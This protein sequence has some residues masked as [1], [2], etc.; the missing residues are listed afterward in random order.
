LRDFEQII[1]WPLRWIGAERQPGLIRV[2]V[3]SDVALAGFLR[4]QLAVMGSLAAIYAAGLGISG[5][6]YG[7]ALGVFAGLVS[8]VP[9][10][11]TLIGLTLALM[12]ALAQGGESS[13]Y[14]GVLVTFG[15]GQLLEGT[16]LTPRLV[17][18]RIGLHPVLVIFA[19][20]AGGALFGFLG[21]LMALPASAIL[22]GV[23]RSNGEPDR[24]TD[25]E[26]AGGT[27]DA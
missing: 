25:G 22:I 13:I 1:R 11:G 7:I 15:V 19:V 10:A 27:A 24:S 8:F 17:G 20:L 3:A 6:E 23:M 2:A 26:D 4:G 12:M 21:V 14:I 5:V 16:V 18:D 9:Y